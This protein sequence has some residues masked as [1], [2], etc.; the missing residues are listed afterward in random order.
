[1]VRESVWLTL[2]PETYR[3]LVSFARERGI[4][5]HEAARIVLRLGIELSAKRGASRQTALPG[6]PR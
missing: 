6:V 4:T 2:D 3:A 1:M 5:L